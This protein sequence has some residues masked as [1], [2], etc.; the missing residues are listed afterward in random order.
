MLLRDLVHST[1]KLE[2]SGV[3]GSNAEAVSSTYANAYRSPDSIAAAGGVSGA[4]Y[5]NPKSNA[6]MEWHL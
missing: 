4:D 1:G 6:S 2:A 5:S 3:D